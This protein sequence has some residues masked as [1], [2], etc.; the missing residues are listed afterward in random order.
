[1][2]ASRFT[3]YGEVLMQALKS[4]ALGMLITGV[5]IVAACADDKSDCRDG[6][7]ELKIKGCSAL[8]TADAKDAIA[9]YSRGAGLS[10][11][12]RP[13]QSYRRL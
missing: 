1:M 8:I 9:F 13:R 5:W 2:L 12:G 11:E 4:L 6:D 7:V 3:A 10:D